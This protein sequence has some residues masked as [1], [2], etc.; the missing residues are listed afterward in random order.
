MLNPLVF[1]LSDYP[2]DRLRALLDPISPPAGISPLA[3][4]IGEPKHTPP[5][6]IGETIKASDGLWDR[7]PPID[8]TPEF[9]AAVADWLTR[10]FSLESDFIDRDQQILPVLSTREAL[11]L[12]AIMA[13]DTSPGEPRPAVLFPNPLYHVYSAAAVISGADAITM[14]ATRET[15]F[16]PDLDALDPATL[17]RAAIMYL[18]SPTNPQG[19]VASAAYLEQAIQLAR[20]HD[21]ILALDECY[22]EI[23]S[24]TPPT[25]G[26][27]ICQKIGGR[28]K[29]VLVFH[30]LSKRSSEP[31]LR[32]G[33]VAGD[34]DLIQRFKLLRNFGG[35][36]MPMPVMA[37]S[38][39]LWRDESHVEV[40]HALY[41]Q[42][43]DF[44]DELLLGHFAYKRPAGGFF[45][46]LD[47]AAQGGGE[48]AAKKLWAEAGL[49]V[50][51]G[52]YLSRP[53]PD[54]SN[55]GSD[56]NCP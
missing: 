9:R 15:G 43:F 41:R 21:F 23:Y 19:T 48:E 55:P 39:A 6:L 24:E 49:R 2:F 30:S 38:S 54:G 16:L 52:A 51:P 33:F 4:S 17:A 5:A 20:H 13:V 10:C 26:A 35:A 37:A 22:S 12:A 31:G 25:G 40:N 32:S 1:E 3:L 36:T 47:V 28:M 18:C 44:A 45:L 8:G 29:N 42:K 27:E 14:P 53:E 7:Y 56:K 34:P 50:L 46:W 11:Y